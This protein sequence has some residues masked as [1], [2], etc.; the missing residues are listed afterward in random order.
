[1]AETPVSEPNDKNEEP[2]SEI[3]KRTGIPYNTL[4]GRVKN[5]HMSIK[6]AIKLGSNRAKIKNKRKYPEVF[7]EGKNLRQLAEEYNIR[8]EKLWD[9]VNRQGRTI[10]EALAMGNEKKGGNK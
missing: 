1:M 8:Y 3:A 2:L 5:R 9:R 4:W 7:F 6:E 10:E